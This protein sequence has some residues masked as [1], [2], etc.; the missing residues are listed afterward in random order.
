MKYNIWTNDDL[1]ECSEYIINFL[2]WCDDEYFKLNDFNT[3]SN[4]KMSAELKKFDT[5]M[6]DFTKELNNTLHIL[7]EPM[8]IDSP[9]EFFSDQNKSV[10]F[11]RKAINMLSRRNKLERLKIKISEDIQHK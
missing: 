10:A 4:Q 9:K 3:P 8:W 1:I 7:D 5:H 11:F 2:I 6:V